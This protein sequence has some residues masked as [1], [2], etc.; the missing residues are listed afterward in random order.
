MQIVESSPEQ[1][2][3]DRPAASSCDAPISCRRGSDAAP[4]RRARHHG[5]R[6]RRARSNSSNARQASIQPAAEATAVP[7]R[8]CRRCDRRRVRRCRASLELFNGSAASRRRP[9]VRH[10]VA[11]RQQPTLP[12]APW[13]NVVANPSFGF[14]ASECG[15]GYTWSEQQPR[16]PVDARG[17]TI[18]CRSAGRGDVPPG[19]GDRAL[20]VGDAAARRVS[21]RPLHRSRHGRATAP[22][23]TGATRIAS[24][25]LP[26]R[27]D[28]RSGEGVSAH[29]AETVRSGRRRVTVTLYVEWVLGENPSRTA[30]ARRDQPRPAT[31]A[32]LARNAFRRISP[33]A[34]P[35]SISS[36]ATRAD[37][38]RRSD[39]VP[40]PQ[41]HA[42]RAGGAAPPSAL[43]SHRR[44]TRPVRR[45]PGPRSRS[46]PDADA[47]RRR[48]ARRSA[49][50][51]RSAAS[52]VQRYR[53][54]PGSRRRASRTRRASG[55]TSSGTVHGHDAR[56][57]DGPD[58]QSA[59]CSTRHW[60][61]ASGDARPSISRAARSASAIS[62]RTCWRCSSP[63]REL[64]R[65]HILRRRLAAVRRG[66]R[67]ALVARAGRPGRAHA[68][69]G[70]SALA[71]V[72]DRCTTSRRPATPRC[73]T[74]PCR[75]SRAAPLNP[76]EHEAVRAS[77]RS[78]EQT[79]SLYEHC[80]RAIDAATSRSA[81][82]ACRSWAPATGT[83]A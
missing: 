52:L 33:I 36:R 14:V 30:P 32:V 62:C 20:L 60:L 3:I 39:R 2:W 10:R 64:A 40:R 66:R 72:R 46:D 71:A 17:A 22:S 79:A 27:A 77:D 76:D 74:S 41:R 45:D 19:R 50:T 78:R 81:R 34:S 37:G 67:A 16:Q 13:S 47:N 43:R 58:A 38:H 11:S 69:L 80:V 55:T 4:R 75:S 8:R 63:R 35:F 12:P 68:L 6:R 61:A 24:T 70:R 26:V 54:P 9:R 59:G 25:L 83:T 42:A 49:R 73:S 23:S 56:P 31:G 7:S 44:R 15:P 5:R 53:A 18:R 21:G 82:T 28:R 65:A 57:R 51:K 48:P 1:P 29:A